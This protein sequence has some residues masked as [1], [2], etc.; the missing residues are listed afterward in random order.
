[1]DSSDFHRGDRVDVI[2]IGEPW[3]TGDIIDISYS[4]YGGSLLYPAFQVRNEDDVREWFPGIC[5]TPSDS[6]L[7]TS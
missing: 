2:L 5:L 3:G 6:S 1:M 4:E 7:T